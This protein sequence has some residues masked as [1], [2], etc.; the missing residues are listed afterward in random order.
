MRPITVSRE[1]AYEALDAIAR[2]S[3]IKAFCTLQNI[4]RTA[5]YNA[6]ERYGLERKP[7][8]RISATEHLDLQRQAQVPPEVYA[9][10]AGLAVETLRKYAWEHGAPLALSSYAEKKAWWT[11]RLDSYS[12][13][14][15]RAFC[16]TNHL[17]LLAVARWWH[18]VN[19]PQASLLW[20][21]SQT[22]QIADDLSETLFQ[23]EDHH[24]ETFAVGQGRDCVPVGI[25]TA[26][27]F[28]T[29]STPVTPHTTH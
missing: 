18:I 14:N 23:Y 27:E 2:G 24:A 21:F 5:L 26:N 17:P 9:F 13:A 16:I 25:R 29:R 12:H 6:F 10:R 22:F 20:G 19:K 1:L 8:A 7:N 11:E 15:A 3:S 4:S 28:F